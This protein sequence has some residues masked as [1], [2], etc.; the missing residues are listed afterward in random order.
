MYA[1]LVA[2]LPV[3]I[4]T[5]VITVVRITTVVVIVTVLITLLIVRRPLFAILGAVS[6]LA[7][8][9]IAIFFF[10]VA[11]AIFAALLIGGTVL[12]IGR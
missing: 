5:L 10:T 7:V 4:V 9:S 2:I 8:R 12:F 6:P 1:V 11:F 3:L